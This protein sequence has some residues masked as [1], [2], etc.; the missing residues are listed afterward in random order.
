MFTDVTISANLSTKLD[1]LEGGSQAPPRALSNLVKWL[2]PTTLLCEQQFVTA[3]STSAN[4]YFGLYSHWAARSLLLSALKALLQRLS[5]RY[6]PLWDLSC[7]A[8][9][10]EEAASISTALSSLLASTEAKISVS[11]AARTLSWS[12]P[13]TCRSSSDAARFLAVWCV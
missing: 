4:P 12:T 3:L 2:S 8:L 9:P 6:L 5:C 11:F 1:L 10:V 13:F 7:R